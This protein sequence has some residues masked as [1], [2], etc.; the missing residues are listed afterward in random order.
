MYRQINQ[1]INQWYC[2][3]VIISVLFFRARVTEE[4]GSL[5]LTQLLA[6]FMENLSRHGKSHEP[7]EIVC[8]AL[9][10][11]TV[12]SAWA[13]SCRLQLILLQELAQYLHTPTFIFDPA[14]S[15]LEK[16]YLESEY[17]GFSLIPVN[18]VSLAPA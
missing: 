4:C 11:F 17:C 18:E 2:V 1:S 3:T 6:A 13:F 8:Y 7:E 5:F 9:G 12:P 14:F 16:S 10:R 15:N